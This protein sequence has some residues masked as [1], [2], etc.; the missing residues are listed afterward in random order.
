MSLDNLTRDL[1]AIDS[2]TG[3]EGSVLEYIESYLRNEG[4]T[5]SIESNEGGL[6]AGRSTIDPVVALVGHVDTVPI[7]KH[8]EILENSETIYGRGAVDMKSGLAVMIRTMIDFQD[9]DIVGIFYK[10]EEGAKEQNGLETLFPEIN[11]KFDISLG[12]ILEPTDNEV[13]LGCQGVVNAELKVEGTEAH[14]A[15]PWLG[16]NAIYKT[17]PLL[18]KLKELSP[19]SILVDELDY[20]EVIS[21]TNISGGI[22]KNV[23]PGEVICGINYRFAPDKTSEDAAAKLTDLLSDYG[24]ISI[25]DV[26]ESAHPNKGNKTVQKFIKSTDASIKPKQAWTDIAR[27]TNA[28]IPALNFGPGSPN[29]A[30]KKNEHVI[31]SD[32]NKCYLLIKKFFMEQN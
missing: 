16:K 5:H 9:H 26:A 3:N 24:E 30:H 12:I 20:K 23:I 4:Y 18:E 14:S 22:A 29:L 8:Q 32:I 27:F 6:I 7:S 17:I 15:R 13:Q 21:V 2:V 1:I 25:Q 10:G 19:E 31:V 11:R 28:G